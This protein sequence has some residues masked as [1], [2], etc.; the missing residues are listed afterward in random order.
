MEVRHELTQQ[1]QMAKRHVCF[2]G[3]A[4]AAG[5][6]YSAIIISVCSECRSE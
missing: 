3:H 5:A 4:C 2:Q 6:A 1:R